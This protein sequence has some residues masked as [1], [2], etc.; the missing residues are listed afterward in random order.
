MSYIVF[1]PDQTQHIVGSDLGPNCLQILSASD[2]ESQ[3]ASTCKLN[4]NPIGLV[5]IV[6]RDN[7]RRQLMGKP[8][9]GR[10]KGEEER[11]G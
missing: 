7:R 10:V 4:S 6:V 9:G 11:R 1:D 5:L 3:L 2:K 8:K